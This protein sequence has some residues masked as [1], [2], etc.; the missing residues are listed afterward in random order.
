MK[1]VCIDFFYIFFK[2]IYFKKIV[3]T[4]NRAKYYIDATRAGFPPKPT[5]RVGDR[6]KVWGLIPGWSG[7]CLN[8]PDW[9]KYIVIS[10]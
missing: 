5:D 10:N 4:G 8:L 9:K 3:Q 2:Y 7:Y 6:L 1:I